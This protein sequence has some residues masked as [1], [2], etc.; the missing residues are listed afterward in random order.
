MCDKPSCSGFLPYLVLSVF[1]F[2]HKIVCCRIFCGLN[3]HTPLGSEVEH[4]LLYSLISEVSVQAFCL[5]FFSGLFVFLL[6]NVECSLYI[7]DTSPLL[8]CDLQIFS[9]SLLLLFSVSLMKTN[10]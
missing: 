7:L 4:L 5:L 8:I 2:S 6:L 9:P 10:F 1:H 3:L